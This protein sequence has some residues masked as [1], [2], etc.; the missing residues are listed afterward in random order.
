MYRVWLCTGYIYV[1]GISEVVPGYKHEPPQTPPHILLHYCNFKVG[2]RK[3]FLNIT[4]K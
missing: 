1:Q 2:R 3:G 4:E